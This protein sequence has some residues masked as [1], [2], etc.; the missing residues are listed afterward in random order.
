M[1]KSLIFFN[2]SLEC[3]LVWKI[4]KITIILMINN[5]LIINC[6]GQDNKIGLKFD[7]NFYVH[8]LDQKIN[9]NDQLVASILNLVQKYKVN[10]NDSF[11]LLVNNGPEAFLQY[12]FPWP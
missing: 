8:T 2:S 11:S 10:F 7:N 5:F 4:E 9:N 6:I 3:K 1:P 12:E